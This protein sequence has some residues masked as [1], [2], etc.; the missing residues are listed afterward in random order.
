MPHPF[1]L[2]V[3]A[4]N[5]ARSFSRSEGTRGRLLKHNEKKHQ[6]LI[7]SVIIEGQSKARE[8]IGMFQVNVMGGYRTVW[9]KM[10]FIRWIGAVWEE[11][12]ENLLQMDFQVFS[13]QTIG[14]FHLNWGLKLFPPSG[15]NI[16]LKS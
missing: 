5:S 3:R 6:S 7:I 16:L 8:V 2:H 10:E 9:I 15:K 4:I 14:H 13:V 1:L 11:E 12:I